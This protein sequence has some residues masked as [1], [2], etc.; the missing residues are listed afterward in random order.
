LP[1]RPVIGIV[2]CLCFRVCEFREVEKKGAS[3]SADRQNRQRPAVAGISAGHVNI[4]SGTIAC[5]CG[6]TCPGEEKRRMVLS[7][8]HVF[9]DVN[10][11]RARDK[12]LQPG[13]ADGGTTKDVLA[14][15]R[16]SVGTVG[17]R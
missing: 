7:N 6:S 5:F 8:N 11:G 13:K 12:L 1:C 16:R 14:V 10:K 15:L 2:W 17:W 9:A 3:C 4:T